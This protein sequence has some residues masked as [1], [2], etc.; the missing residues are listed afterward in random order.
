MECVGEVKGSVV[1]DVSVSKR[2]PAVLGNN[3]V[4]PP[5]SRYFAAKMSTH[6][7]SN[8]CLGLATT[9]RR[10]NGGVKADEVIRI[11]I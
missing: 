3:I 10:R 1:W 8:H 11:N 2:Q 4:H 5:V 7:S 9:C 6:M